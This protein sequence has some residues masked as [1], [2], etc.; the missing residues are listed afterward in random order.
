MSSKIIIRRMLRSKLFMV[1]LFGVLVVVILVV[2][3]PNIIVHDPYTTN[4]TERLMPPEYLEKGWHG[5]ILGTDAVG[6]DILT[7]LLMGGR[8]SLVI[9]LFVTCT[10]CFIGV[11]LGMIA[12]YFGGVVDNVL[13]RFCD[14]VNS[15][16]DLLLAIVVVSIFG[17]GLRNLVVVLSFCLWPSFARLTR[18]NV[19]VMRNKE[20]V[21]AS[22][23]LGANHFF[24]MFREIL[25]N[26]AT[27]LLIQFSQMIAKVIRTEASLSFLDLGVPPPEPSWGG[28][29]S[30]GRTYIQVA[31]WNVVF[32]GIC[33]MWT[34]MAFSFLGDGLRDVLD[35]KRL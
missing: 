7:R 14:V 34:L 24:I 30:A 16:P 2:I 10:V 3:A 35:P 22:E 32:P 9:S 8:Y 20:F 15:I 6:R 29:I 17:T 13:M 31:P 23:A 18:N 21:R 27:P 25:S 1:G 12:G 11:T 26:V 4:L 19:L 28:M 33:L 5:N